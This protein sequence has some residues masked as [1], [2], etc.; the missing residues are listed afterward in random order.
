MLTYDLQLLGL[1]TYILWQAWFKMEVSFFF[2]G[3]NWQICYVSWHSQLRTAHSLLLVS[4]VCVVWCAMVRHVPPKLFVHQSDWVSNMCSAFQLP[5]MHDC[6]VIYCHYIVHLTGGVF[7]G[8]SG[9]RVY[10]PSPLTWFCWERDSDCLARTVAQQHDSAMPTPIY[11]SILL[12]W[13]YS[14]H[15]KSYRNILI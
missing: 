5:W 10:F 7:S 11:D 13:F 9:W 12:Y 6:T 8:G 4:C 14:I 1:S 15:I 2:A 3:W